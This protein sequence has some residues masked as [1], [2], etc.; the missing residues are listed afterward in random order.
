MAHFPKPFFKKAR[1]LWYV[2]INRKQ[3]NLG[4]DR[5]EAFRQY[6]QLMLNPREQSV[7]ADSLA[8][9]VDAYLEWVQKHRAADTYEWYRYRL[10]RLVTKYPEMRGNTL[11]PYHIEQWVDD[12]DLAVTSQRNYYRSIKTCL[13][14]AVKQG[15]LER[16]PIAALEVP[17]ADRRE[18]YV[19]PDEFEKL[20]EFVTND[21]FRDLLVTTYQTGCRPQESLKV[22]AEF[23]D[24]QNGRWTFPQNESKGK[25]APRVIYLTE[26]ALGIT[27]RLVL[28]Y[29]NGPLFRN[30]RGKPWTTEAVNCFFDRIRTKMGR[31]LAMAAG[32]LVT[33]EEIDAFIPKLC[34]TRT[35]KGVKREK[36]ERK[37]RSEAIR[38]L[39]DRKARRLAS[40]YSLYAMRHSWATNALKCG[41]D[42]LTVAILMGH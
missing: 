1:S 34:P 19:P 2:E 4:P 22:T 39:T 16:N 42:S 26:D 5:D 9:V 21:A 38:K 10:Q 35:L 8:G 31:E 12:Y 17:G 24:L 41:V 36:S 14:W 30:S 32:D 11:R 18:T 28:K 23:V 20:L 37:L 33:D 7:S 29:P 27:R 40:R 6:H 13:R 25:K 15:Y 3:I